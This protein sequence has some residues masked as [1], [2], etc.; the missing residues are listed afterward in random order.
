M[1]TIFISYANESNEHAEAVR[2]LADH[3]VIDGLQVT[4]DQYEPHPTVDWITWMNTGLDQADVVLM[5]CSPAY[6]RR[7]MRREKA[8]VGLGAQWEGHLIHTRLYDDLAQAHKYIPILFPGMTPDTIPDALR[9]YQRYNVA[10]PTMDDAGYEAL[11]R[12]LTGQPKHVRPTPGSI[13]SLPRSAEPKDERSAQGDNAVQRTPASGPLADSLF[14]YL[15][16]DQYDTGIH[17]GQ[18]GRSASL[19]EESA[20]QKRGERLDVKPKLYLTGW[21]V[22][23]LARMPGDPRA[24]VLLENARRGVL[25]LLDGLWVRV[26]MAASHHTSPLAP[27]VTI[28]YRHTI[29]M[30]IDPSLAP[31]SAL[32]ATMLDD[33]S[34][35]QARSGGWRQCSCEHT[36]EDLWATCYAIGFLTSQ[37]SHAAALHLREGGSA[38]ATGVMEATL[39]WLEREWHANGWDY[40]FSMEENAPLAFHEVAAALAL[41]RPALAGAVLQTFGTFLDDALHPRQAYLSQVRTLSPHRASIRLA[42]AFFLYRTEPW[43][44]ATYRSMLDWLVFETRHGLP[45]DLNSPEAAMYLDMVLHHNQSQPS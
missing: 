4:L 9:H 13:K 3:L 30:A 23:V 33:S 28:T 45:K 20:Y 24:R 25:D 21:P 44:E 16:L 29:L 31:V 42:Y 12:H 34:D 43:A 36:D 18:F 7:V 2:T 40:G 11:Y 22:F 15:E 19:E 14:A 41:H 5:V 35:L 26:G 38:R 27:P 17:R 37:R 32:L 39:D 1:K 10:R 6:Y 8:G